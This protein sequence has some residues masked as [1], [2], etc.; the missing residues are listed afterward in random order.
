MNI[1]FVAPALPN[2]D[3]I[4]ETRAITSTHKAHVLS[5]QVTLADLYSAVTNNEY[6][7]IH[8]VSHVSADMKQLDT[9]MLSDGEHLDLKGAVRLVKLA[10]AKLVV[11]SMCLASR[12]ATYLVKQG[13]PCVIYTTVEIEDDSAWELPTAFYEQCRR[14][15]RSGKPLDFRA[16]FDMVDGA[17]GTYGI[18][19]SGT[20]Y[21]GLLQ[22]IYKALDALTQ[23][24]DGLYRI[25]EDQGY[26]LLG[27]TGT[28]NRAWIYVIA[29]VLILLIIASIITI[30][31][32]AV[33]LWSSMS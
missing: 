5:G 18:V 20:Y 10:N 11:F 32:S 17:D 1:L 3:A 25:L 6:D 8:F 31:D 7:A 13:V 27:V 16:L 14:A 29:A 28:N 2:I 30:G 22:P 9:L 24:V 23:R 21:N 19:S 4:P 33:S 26:S 15:E 12:F